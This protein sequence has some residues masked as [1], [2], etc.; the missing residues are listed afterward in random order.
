MEEAVIKG[1]G[2]KAARDAVGEIDA[3]LGRHRAWVGEGAALDP[4]R[5]EDA[6]AGALPV[7]LRGVDIAVDGG[8]L[9]E[10]RGGAR[11]EPQVHLAGEGGRHRVDE[12]GRLH[13]LDFRV[14]VLLR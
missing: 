12:G 7:D 10:F 14:A 4:F 6:L 5:G 9:G 1:A 8:D 13:A 2:E 11:F 3:L